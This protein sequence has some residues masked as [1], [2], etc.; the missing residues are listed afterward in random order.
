MRPA[1]ANAT[2]SF[3]GTR[4]PVPAIY[5]RARVIFGSGCFAVTPGFTRVSPTSAME[6]GPDAGFSSK[7]VVESGYEKDEEGA[8]STATT[9]RCT[10]GSMSC[11][12]M[13]GLFNGALEAT[14]RH[15]ADAKPRYTFVSGDRRSSTRRLNCRRASGWVISSLLLLGSKPSKTSESIVIRSLPPVLRCPGLLR[16]TVLNCIVHAIAHR[17]RVGAKIAIEPIDDV[18]NARIILIRGDSDKAEQEAE[19]H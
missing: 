18:S 10:Y 8:A 13:R 2:L 1:D 7:W 12:Q 5:A 6:S 3:Y 19:E 16:P 17:L 4:I 15:G 11:S 14:T 9:M